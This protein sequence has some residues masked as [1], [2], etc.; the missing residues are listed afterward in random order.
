MY[1][2]FS[3]SS[4]VFE[5]CVRGGGNCSICKKKN[6]KDGVVS[7]QGNPS[8]RVSCFAHFLSESKEFK[9][10]YSCLRFF[11]QIRKFELQ[12]DFSHLSPPTFPPSHLLP[13]K[14][15]SARERKG[16]NSVLCGGSPAFSPGV[17]ACM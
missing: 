3:S 17:F 2:F 8:F 16:L 13:C 11:Y 10:L 15:P 7:M 6:I 9:T 14:N 1:I 5:H 12:K 4:L